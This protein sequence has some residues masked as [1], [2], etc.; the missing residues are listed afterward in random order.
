MTPTPLPRRALALA[1]AALVM[2]CDFAPE[3]EPEAEDLGTGDVEAIERELTSGASYLIKAVH[4]G[5]CVDVAGASTAD[6]ANLHQWDCHGRSNQQFRVTAT[7][8]G[9]YQV[10]AVHSGKCVD[11]YRAGTVNGTKVQQWRCNGQNNQRWRLLAMGGGQYQIQAVH[12]GKCF[13]I[14]GASSARGANLQQWTCLGR[15][16]QKFTLVPAGG[17]GGTGGSGTGG[18]G[19]GGS[20][21]GGTGGSGGSGPSLAWRRANL[22]YF[23]SYPDPGSEECVQYNGCTWAGQFAF[24]DGQQSQTWVREHNIAAVHSKDAGT[25]R[26]K[27]LRVRQGTRQIDVKVY[28]MCSDT[29]CNG[30]CT[31]NSRDTG[32]L[33][34][35]ESY[36]AARFGS[37]SGVVE[38]ACLDCN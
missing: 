37:S 18:T 3:L 26:L 34:D 13:E 14:A 17:T 25:Y 32:F 22:T 36:T 9:V 10:T 21:A 35:L 23:T 28:D 24:C 19:T 38:W 8:S 29:D 2:A 7:A 11:V 1:L 12:S 15:T 4:S 6:G 16:N 31:A 20:G 27:T 5:K 30:C 33:I